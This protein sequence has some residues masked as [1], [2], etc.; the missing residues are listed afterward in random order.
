ML[1]PAPQDEIF[2]RCAEF[3]IG[4]IVWSPLAQGVLSGKY[5][6]DAPPP[7]ESRASHASMGAML[8]NRWLQSPLLTAVQRVKQIA[9]RDAGVHLAQFALAWILRRQEVSSAIVGA[10]RPGQVAENA[11]AAEYEI[12]PELFAKADE[13]LAPFR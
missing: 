4:Q 7:P 9:E 5:T 1:W 10:T 6:P 2:P 13:I 11:A 3:G 8:P 12:T